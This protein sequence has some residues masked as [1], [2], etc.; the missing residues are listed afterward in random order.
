MWAGTIAHNGLLNTG[1]NF[2]DWATHMIEH[3][4]SARYDIAHGAGLAIVF[5]AWM[6][7]VYKNDL[8]RFVK[9]AKEVFALSGESKEEPVLQGVE[10]L[11]QF[12]RDIGMPTSLKEAGIDEQYLEEM[13]ELAVSKGPLGNFV[14]LEKEDVLNI[15]NI[16][17]TY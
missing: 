7:Y 10:A 11:K 9:F 13:A 14:K 2:G 1:S 17:Q 16:I 5:P 8:D 3:E 15:L 6:K 12:F 4:L